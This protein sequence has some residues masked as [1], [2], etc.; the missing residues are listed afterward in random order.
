M[1]LAHT[2]RT[3]VFLIGVTTS[4]LALLQ[5]PQSVGQ[6]MARACPPFK[7]RAP[8]KL[9]RLVRAVS[10]LLLSLTPTRYRVLASRP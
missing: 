5:R 6:Q 10:E 4:L 3:W 1:V 7:K 2:R 9:Y 8:T